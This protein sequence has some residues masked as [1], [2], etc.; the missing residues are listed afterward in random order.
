MEEIFE[1]TGCR[2]PCRYKKY[3]FVG[4]PNPSD[5]ESEDYIFS[6]WAVSNRTKVETEELIYPSSSLVAEFGGTLSLFLGISFI[7]FWDNFS[8][9]KRFLYTQDCK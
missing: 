8:S 5:F 3:S 7:S 2:K 1:I 9:L 4:E 6:L